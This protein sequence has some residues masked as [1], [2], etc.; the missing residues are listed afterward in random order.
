MSATIDITKYLC[1][2]LYLYYTF[3]HIINDKVLLFIYMI[4]IY[5][6]LSFIDKK[7]SQL[8]EMQ[9]TLIGTYL[10]VPSVAFSYAL[11]LADRKVIE[12]AVVLN[13]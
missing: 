1:R 12:L 9:N 3:T 10:H 7:V 13:S 5:V 11:R 4:W 6:W 8:V 2:I